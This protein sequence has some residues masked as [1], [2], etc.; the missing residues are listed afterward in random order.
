MLWS[1]WSQHHAA[2]PPSAPRLVKLPCRDRSQIRRQPAAVC[3]VFV[4]EELRGH[5]GLPATYW[6]S[7][8][9]CLGTD[10]V[11]FTV[12]ETDPWCHDQHRCLKCLVGLEFGCVFFLRL[13]VGWFCR[14]L[15]E[16]VLQNVTVLLLLV[17]CHISS[18]CSVPPLLILTEGSDLSQWT[19]V[20]CDD[21]FS[22]GNCMNR[23]ARMLQV[24][25]IDTA[26]CHFFLHG[27]PP[28]PLRRELVVGCVLAAVASA[29]CSLTLPLPHRDDK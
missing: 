28:V 16:N 6:C 17:T 26:A 24:R 21:D 23:I 11:S 25:A 4:R 9:R 5:D 1:W 18:V 8:V 2:C 14:A 29:C 3:M 20:R 13:L 22:E 15:I 27:G 7:V 12:S 10:M 19:N